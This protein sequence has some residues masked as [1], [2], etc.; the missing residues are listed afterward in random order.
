MA[1]TEK[2]I[3]SIKKLI[4]K[5][6]QIRN[7]CTSA[8]IHHGKC[9]SGS[10]RLMLTNGNVITAKELFEKSKNIGSKFKETNEELIYDIY[11]KKIEI[12]S[13]NKKTGKIEK[14][15]IELAWKLQNDI[16]FKITLRNGFEVSTTP[17]HK[18]L[19]LKNNDF[20]DKEAKDIKLGDR[21]VC[22][23]KLD[24]VSDVDLKKTFLYKLSK[25]NFMLG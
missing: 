8:H 24:I 16:L 5:P 18:Y 2:S 21:I 25:K 12:F 9:V 1:S 10:T 6:E 19:V 20:I 23:R 7:I 17:E 3:E 14:K 15:P 22:A 4:A 13:L 11:N